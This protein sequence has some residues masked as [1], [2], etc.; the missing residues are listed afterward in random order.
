MIQ[1]LL[2]NIRQV[3]NAFVAALKIQSLKECIEDS[4][5]EENLI[6]E[7]ALLIQQNKKIIVT[8]AMGLTQHKN[9]VDNIKEI[10]K[11]FI[12]AW[13]YWIT[14]SWCLSCSRP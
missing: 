14:R 6:R 13:K 2:K 4:G 9:A 12:T 7:A 10:V 11:P 8:W 3:M 5:V 1:P